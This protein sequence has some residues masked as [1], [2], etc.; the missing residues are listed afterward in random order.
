[1]G[2]IVYWI[3]PIWPV[4]ASLNQLGG[5]YAQAHTVWCNCHPSFHVGTGHHRVHPMHDWSSR[6]VHVML[7]RQLDRTARAFASKEKAGTFTRGVHDADVHT[8]LGQHVLRGLHGRHEPRERHEPRGLRAPRELREPR[9]PLE[10]RGL[11]VLVHV[12]ASVFGATWRLY[13][14]L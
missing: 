11:H 4:E 1:M 14:G 2:C 5:V 9:G 13:L 6:V 7:P 8:P 12:H 3:M 10:Q